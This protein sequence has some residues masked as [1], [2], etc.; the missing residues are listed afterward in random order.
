VDGERGA[1]GARAEDRDVHRAPSG[2][3]RGLA[4]LL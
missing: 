3:A 1:P 2:L 4:A